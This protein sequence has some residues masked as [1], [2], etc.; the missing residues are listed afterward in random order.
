MTGTKLE[1]WQPT[2]PSGPPD[3][4]V[5]IPGERPAGE[6]VNR[7]ATDPPPSE[8]AEPKT[9]RLPPAAGTAVVRA[10]SG[11]TT[12]RTSNPKPT[13]SVRVKRTRITVTALVMLALG[14]SVFAGYVADRDDPRPQV[15]LPSP[16]S[17]TESLVTTT[18]L[19]TV[20]VPPA[21]VPISPVS[22]VPRSSQPP[23]VSSPEPGG[24]PADSEPATVVPSTAASS[25]Q[26][27]A[28]A[29]APCDASPPTG[30]PAT[31]RKGATR[32]VN[33]WT[34]P[35]GWSYFT[36]GSGF[37]VAV[38]DDW[39]YQRIGTTYCFRNS[40]NSRVLSLDTGRDPAAD[41]VQALQAEEARLAGPGGLPGYTRVRI[42]AVAL[43][44]RAAD[45][46]YR[47]RTRDGAAR[48]A[49]VRWFVV[50]GR[51]FALGWTTA[52]KTWTADLGKLQMVRGTFYAA[53]ATR[54][55]AP[56]PS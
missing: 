10:A 17:M 52:E 7:Q 42:E 56:S 24:S 37:H 55:P 16:S 1:L 20:P 18:P 31:P 50:D 48:H 12:S 51:A 4:G 40:R 32:G 47:Y 29:S 46:E 15:F 6:P 43:L 2:A 11:D 49:I 30:L 38:P 22:P 41:P 27:G 26:R 5:R 45:W 53:G 13:R 54:R 28:F 36:D 8:P 3:A 39:T 9:S 25:P 19:P 21:E 23:Q 35:S 33:G 14:G 44:H 34:L